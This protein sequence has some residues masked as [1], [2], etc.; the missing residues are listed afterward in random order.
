MNIFVKMSK[1]ENCLDATEKITNILKECKNDFYLSVGD[2][3]EDAQQVKN[4]DL[5]M[6]VG[7]DGTLLSVSGYASKYNK[8]ILGINLG[9]LGFL[10]A[11]E[12][13]HLEQ[14]ADFFK[15]PEHFEIKKHSLLKA[16]INRGKWHYCL[17]DAVI[18]KSSFS[19][20]ISTQICCND[21][22]IA[23]FVC[24]CIIL[25]TSTGST[26]YSLSAGG[27]IVDN[28]LKA[29]ILSPVAVHSLKATP[30]VFAKDKQIKIT[31]DSERKQDIYISFDGENHKKLKESDT[32]TVQLS[33]KALNI[34]S[35]K[36]MGQFT[37][38]DSKLKLR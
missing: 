32:V 36:N 25:A 37:K 19:N 8:P 34:Y 9:R 35:A 24:D 2:E 31:F 1:N 29:L 27:P 26:A 16:K 3:K 23:S 17:N 20:T 12:G 5:I 7:G 11:V 21:S 6:T 38:V 4:C 28:D 10:T 33:N 18:A 14:I 30:M 15:N 22:K 13:T